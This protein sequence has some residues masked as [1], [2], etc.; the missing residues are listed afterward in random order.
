MTASEGE[1]KQEL[2]LDQIKSGLRQVTPTLLLVTIATGFAFA[3]GSGLG[4]A[5]TQ[6][7]ITSSRNDRRGRHK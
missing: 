5:V 1:P 7:Y 6:R 3:I 2:L 4:H